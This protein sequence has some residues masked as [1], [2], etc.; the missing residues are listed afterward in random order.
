MTTLFAGTALHPMGADP[1]DAA[2]AFTEYALDKHWVWSHLA[3][4]IGVVLLALALIA[5]VAERNTAPSALWGTISAALAIALIAIASALQ[6]VDGVALKRM[7]DR[8]ASAGPELKPCVFEAAFAVRQIEIGLAGFLSFITGLAITAFGLA[9]Y[10]SPKDPRWFAW[11]ALAN[12]GIFVA[13]GI[14]QQT[15]GFSEVSMMLSM[16]AGLMFMVWMTALA[17]FTWRWS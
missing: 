9:I 15:T 14:A 17:T 13:S 3:Q 1:N 4:F 8:W 11:A 10:F 16:I 6:A 2:A 5:F 7:V 12:G